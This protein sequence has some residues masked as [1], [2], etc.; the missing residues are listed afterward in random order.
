MPPKGRCAPRSR[1]RSS[2]RRSP[3]PN[4]PAGRLGSAAHVTIAVVDTRG[5]I[6]GLVRSSDAPVFGIDV[7]VQKA[8]TAMFFSHAEAF[9]QLSAAPAAVYLFSPASSIARYPQALRAF[10]GDAAA[11]TG[12][13]AWSV[14]AIGNI[15]RPF[16]PDGIDGTEAGPLSTR[17]GEW[18][19]FNVGFQLD[20]VFN[21]LVKSLLGDASE[22]CAGRLAAGV[23]TVAPDTGI[24][25]L[26]N[27]AQVFPGGVPIYRGSQLVGGIGVSG[28]G[29]DQDDMVAFLGLANAG[30]A[31]QGAIGNAPAAMR[32]DRLTPRGVRLR[33]V[34]CPQAP[35]NG[36]TEQDACNGL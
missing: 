31:L 32:A 6:L 14:R 25:R 30:S 2:R 10:L 7:A 28:D 20:L 8:R 33:Y 34:Q 13:T 1:R 9:A 4:A 15:H 29:V 12:S 21:Q 27:G 36:S 3:W 23:A 5:D 19:P 26:R 22:G 24:V 18:S 17:F 16:F 11:L 35:F